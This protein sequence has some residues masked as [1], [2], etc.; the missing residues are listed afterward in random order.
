VSSYLSLWKGLIAPPTPFVGSHTSAKPRLSK[1]K[2]TDAVRYVSTVY[3]IPARLIMADDR[4]RDITRARWAA[5]AAVQQA[6]GASL[7]EIGR[8]FGRDHTTVLNG[9]RKHKARTAA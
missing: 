2:A 5:F 4:R 1:A 6:T 8:Y 7:L 3:G 9:I